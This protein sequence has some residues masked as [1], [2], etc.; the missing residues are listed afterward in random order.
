MTQSPD[1]RFETRAPASGRAVVVAPE[2]EL[3]CLI[4]DSSS[5]G[6]RI[7][8]D[9]KLALPPAIQL[10]DL[11][12]GVAIDADVAWSKGHRAGLMSQDTIF[13]SALVSGNDT[14]PVPANSDFTERRHQPRSIAKSASDSRMQGR[15]MEFA[16]F[17]IIAAAVGLA[18]V[19]AVSQALARPLEEV[20][21]ALK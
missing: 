12:Q 15:A 13:V 20:Q 7:R 9:R 11:S 21:S 4:M 14:A 17:A 3:P 19:S 8:M 16:C 1:R 2:L 5:Q 10:V 18:G 6:L